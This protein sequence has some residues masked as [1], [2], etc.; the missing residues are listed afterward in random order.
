MT[1][2]CCGWRGKNVTT[3]GKDDHLCGQKANG[4]TCRREEK[5]QAKV[6]QVARLEREETERGNRQHSLALPFGRDD[7]H[8]EPEDEDVVKF[9]D[10][11]RLVGGFRVDARHCLDIHGLSGI[12]FPSSPVLSS[13]LSPNSLLAVVAYHHARALLHAH[14]VD[15]D[16]YIGVTDEPCRRLRQHTQQ[17][18]RFCRMIVIARVAV[19]T[20][21]KDL[22]RYLIASLQPV[23]NRSKG[24]ES[25]S[26]HAPHNYVYI[27]YGQAAY[28]LRP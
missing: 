7:D 1:C 28:D 17:K 8:D 24:G 13:G 22:E 11:Q 12:P 18:K 23:L 20:A 16:Y 6:L 27:G 10:L 9:L 14:N 5:V 19:P 21:A 4:G 2:S 15:G 3:C 26:P 25:V